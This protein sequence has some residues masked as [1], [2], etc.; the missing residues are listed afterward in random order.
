MKAMAEIP[1]TAVL[2]P[3]DPPARQILLIDDDR[4]MSAMLAEYLAPEGFEVH[5]A[6]TAAAGLDRAREGGIVLIILD[7]MLP[8][9]DGFNVLRAIRQKSGIPVIMLTTRAAVADKVSGLEAGAD[10]YVPKP[11]TPIELLARMRSVLRR[12]Q[13]AKFGS[14]F[15]V[16]DDLILDTGARTVERQGAQIDCTAAEFDV[17][18]ALACSA[19]QVVAR[20]RLTRI[21]LGRTPYAGDRGVDNLV[22]ALRRKLGPS[23]DGKER[24]RSVRNKGYVYVHRSPQVAQ[25]DRQ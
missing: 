11:F 20:E 13:P 15:L 25:E 3:P 7:V 10:D 4:E 1:R 2:N 5:L 8:D 24:V 16:V 22:S 9:T 6:H 17:L 19:G 23:A 21:A 12:G 14:A 18:H